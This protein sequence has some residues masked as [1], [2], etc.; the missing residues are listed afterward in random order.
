[1]LQQLLAVSISAFVSL[2]SAL[3]GIVSSVVGI[4]ISAITAGIKKYKSIINKKKKKHDKIVL[5][6]KTNLDIIE[7]L[8]SKALIDSYISHD[9]FFSVNNVSTEYNEIKEEIKNPETS[10]EYTIEIWL[11]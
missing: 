8:V 6:G 10:V 2:F 1:M 11:I 7:V 4:K 5:L 9:K 3:V